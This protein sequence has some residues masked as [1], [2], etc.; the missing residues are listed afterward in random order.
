MEEIGTNLQLI[1]YVV[2]TVV[3]IVAFWFNIRTK[4]SSLEQKITVLEHTIDAMKTDRDKYEERA[5]TETSYLRD[6]IEV[7]DRNI[8][9]ISTEL[10]IHN[11]HL[12][13]MLSLLIKRIDKIEEEE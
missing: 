12:A 6:R 7:M 1:A 11:A 8:V 9:K 10:E 13:T 2:G 5:K 3:S 4:V